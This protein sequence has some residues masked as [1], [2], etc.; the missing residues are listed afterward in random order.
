[1]QGGGF[2]KKRV[3]FTGAAVIRQ[4][5]QHKGEPPLKA[6]WPNPKPDRRWAHDNRVQLFCVS[7]SS[8]GL[9]T[10]KDL[11]FKSTTAV[12]L[13]GPRQHVRDKSGRRKFYQPFAV[14]KQL[15]VHTGRNR[16]V[17]L[18]KSQTSQVLA[19]RQS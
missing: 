6:R 8:Q 17:K 18:Q 4:E 2:R 14:P 1:M 9:R 19:S 11:L 5:Q 16:W 10:A 15:L 12:T 3:L 13:Q 7:A